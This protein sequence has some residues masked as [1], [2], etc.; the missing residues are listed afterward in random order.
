MTNLAAADDVALALGLSDSDELTEAQSKR[1]AGLLARVSSEFRREAERVFTPGESTV[2]LLTVDGRVRLAEPIAEVSSASMQDCD[3]TDVS[4][5][6]S[7]D[8]QFVELEYAG[9][10]LGSGVP[11]TVTYTHTTDVPDDVV[12]TVASIVARHLTLDPNVGPVTE[13]YAGPFRQRFADWANQTAL[14]TAD[15]VAAARAYRY[16]GSAVIVQRP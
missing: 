10:R 14:L 13:M 3:G 7:V 1:V 15:D 5:T 6:T 12:A 8:G 2:R 16:P 4:L 11:V 9:R